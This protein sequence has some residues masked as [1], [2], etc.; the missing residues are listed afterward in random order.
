MLSRGKWNRNTALVRLNIPEM[1]E[2]P[3]QQPGQ[4]NEL[5]PGAGTACLIQ[6]EM[7]I[8]Q[9]QDEGTLAEPP[10]KDY[11]WKTRHGWKYRQKGSVYTQTCVVLKS[12]A[13]SQAG[14]Q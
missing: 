12:N 5:V 6:A 11:R 8:N 3:K 13:F 4:V 9:T 2:E 10:G 7:E 1:S 14:L